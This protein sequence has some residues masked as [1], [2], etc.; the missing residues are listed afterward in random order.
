MWYEGSFKVLHK[1]AENYGDGIKFYLIV[2][3]NT[4]HTLNSYGKKYV[5][6][7]DFNKHVVGSEIT[8]EYKIDCD[9]HLLTFMV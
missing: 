3:G 8:L 7:T 4:L 2:T 5:G 6:C 9:T 1:S